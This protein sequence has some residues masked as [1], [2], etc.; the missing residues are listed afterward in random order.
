[1]H[2]HEKDS[3]AHQIYRDSAGHAP[4]GVIKLPETV[5][6]VRL[7]LIRRYLPY[8]FS[9]RTRLFFFGI[10]GRGNHTGDR[11]SG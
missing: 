5:N 8:C 6:P 11:A 3:E 4:K 7:L 2:K 1:M 10:L 9:D